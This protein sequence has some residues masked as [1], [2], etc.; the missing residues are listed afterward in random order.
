LEVRIEIVKTLLIEHDV[1]KEIFN[2]SYFL[3][4]IIIIALVKP[5]VFYNLVWLFIIDL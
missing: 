1:S 2:P 4:T 3:T 5:K